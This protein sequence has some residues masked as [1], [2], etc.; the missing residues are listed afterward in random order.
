MTTPSTDNTKA[1]PGTC[2][3]CGCSDRGSIESESYGDGVE[4]DVLRRCS[5]CGCRWV[6]TYKALP[7]RVEICDEGDLRA[8]LKSEWEAGNEAVTNGAWE[9]PEDEIRECYGS[10]NFMSTEEG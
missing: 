3:C 4:T 6:E 2:P 8:A 7:E 10:W 9:W 5:P 1:N